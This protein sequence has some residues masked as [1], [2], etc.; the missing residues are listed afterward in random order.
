MED[1]LHIASQIPDFAK[2]AIAVFISLLG[3]W[4]IWAKTKKNVAKQESG[5]AEHET[6]TVEE[7][8][9]QDR[10]RGTA[11]DFK[12][13]RELVNTLQQQM[14][15]MQTE[16][17]EQNQKMSEK[18][19]DRIEKLRNDYDGQ[20]KKLRKDFDEL[21]IEFQQVNRNSIT[22]NNQLEKILTEKAELERVVA[23]KNIEI[24]A[25]KSELE[26]DGTFG[27]RIR[28][29]ETRSSHVPRIRLDQYKKLLIIE[30]S[31]TPDNAAADSIFKPVLAL[32]PDYF[33]RTN[34][35]AVEFRLTFC[36]TISI[37][38]IQAIIDFFNTQYREHRRSIS[39]VWFYEEGDTDWCEQGE[40]FREAS[41]FPFEV[42]A[43]KK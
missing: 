18:Y 37:R 25:L 19:E 14:I 10:K 32:L 16:H 1:W 41:E 12:T 11:E 26:H 42:K 30:G 22:L 28:T 13:L 24:M 31:S 5:A 40:A 17:L 23:K 39:A 21:H 3:G 9:E 38:R 29:Q 15:K 33:E 27:I 6:K 2:G 43:E 35:L 7:K 4:G 8:V 34:E 36:N 20:I